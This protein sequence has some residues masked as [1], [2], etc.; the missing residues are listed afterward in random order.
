MLLHACQLGLLLASACGGWLQSVSTT[1][2][3]NRVHLAG[4][5]WEP[6]CLGLWKVLSGCCRPVSSFVPHH[7]C[8]ATLAHMRQRSGAHTGTCVLLCTCAVPRTAGTAGSRARASEPPLI[9]QWMHLPAGSRRCWAWLCL[10]ALPVSHHDGLH[11]GT[12]RGAEGPGLLL[13]GQ[14]GAAQ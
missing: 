10:L 14:A 1:L 5:R 8:E 9:S 11:G 12:S 3:C 2:C 7:A 4:R 13:A 6:Y